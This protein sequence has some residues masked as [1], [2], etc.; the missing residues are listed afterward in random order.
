[1]DQVNG[2]EL[3]RLGGQGTTPPSGRGAARL[4][5]CGEQRAAG[6]SGPVPAGFPAIN[7][8]ILGKK[9]TLP[10]LLAADY[11]NQPAFQDL[12]TTFQ[13]AYPD[14][15]LNVTNAV[16]EDIPTKVKTAALGGTPV[17]VAHQHAFVYGHIGVAEQVDDLWNQWG[18]AGDFLPNSLQDVT[19]AGHKYGIP[20]DVNCLFTYYNKDLFASVN[21]T[22]PP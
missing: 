18:K 2:S 8:N 21:A 12:Y 17:D 11:Y 10:I 19:W 6:P 13:K 9:I 5:A 4:A 15:K 16:W 3:E 20:L 7:N 22:P 1:M 14:I